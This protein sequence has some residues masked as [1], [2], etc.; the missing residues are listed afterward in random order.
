MV[1]PVTSWCPPPQTLTLGSDEVHVW[2]AALDLK[3][4]DV[5]S[6]RLTLSAEELARAERFYFRRDREHFVVAHGLLRAILGQYLKIEPGQLQFCYN[7]YGKPAL[8][9]TFGRDALRFNMSHSYGLALFAVTCG[10]EIGVDLERLR[11][12]LAD[13]QIAERF[14]SPREAAAL[15]ALPTNM[16]QEGFFTCWTRKEAYI[17]AIGEGLTLSLDQFDV[18]LAPGEPAALVSTSTDPQEASRWSLRGLAP[19]A[20]YVGALAVEG[21][22]L[23][24]KCWQ[25]SERWGMQVKSGPILY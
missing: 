4:A 2:R 6:L 10:R 1:L 9:R 19:N 7:P 15:R 12:H 5:H 8:A 23:R 21:H 16:R 22:D 20:G 18:S 25:W 3:S 11:P 13:E 17:K 24:I 14:L